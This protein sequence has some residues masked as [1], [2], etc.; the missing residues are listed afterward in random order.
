MIHRIVIPDWLPFRSNQWTGRHWSVISKM[1]KETAGFIAA[2]ALQC[3]VPKAKGRRR[4][5]L[6]LTL[7]PR[8]RQRDKDSADKVFLDACVSAQMLIDDS[9]RG[10]EGR[11]EVTFLKGPKKSTTII[12]EDVA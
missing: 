4:V 3:S 2:Y 7:S 10:L 5:S 6:V 11:V 1:K 9:D 8:N 12:L